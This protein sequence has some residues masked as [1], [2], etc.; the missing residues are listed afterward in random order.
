[1]D[2]SNCPADIAD[3]ERCDTVITVEV[4]I[5]PRRDR[6]VQDIGVALAALDLNQEEDEENEDT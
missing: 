1:M 2:V 4:G 5:G 3:A 6:Y